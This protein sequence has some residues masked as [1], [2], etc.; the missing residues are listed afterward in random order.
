MERIRNEEFGLQLFYNSQR[1]GHN[2]KRER[3]FFLVLSP[4]VKKALHTIREKECE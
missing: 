2:D 1:T 3:S 4:S